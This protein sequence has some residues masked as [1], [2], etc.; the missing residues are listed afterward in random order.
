MKGIRALTSAIIVLAACV[1]GSRGALSAESLAN[2]FGGMPPEY[3]PGGDDWHTWSGRLEKYNKSFILYFDR[4][5]NGQ[6][7]NRGGTFYADS[8][9]GTSVHCRGD[10][11]YKFTKRGFVILDLEGGCW[12]DLGENINFTERWIDLGRAGDG[13]YNCQYSNKSETRADCEYTSKK[14]GQTYN[15]KMQRESTD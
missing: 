6:I 12:K 4:Q 13:I 11:G 1:L 5:S 9:D 8:I 10:T 2:P 3:G 15:V 7:L 14:N